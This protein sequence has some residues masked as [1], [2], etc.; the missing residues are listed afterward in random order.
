MHNSTIKSIGIL[1]GGGDCP[2]LNAVIRAVFLRATYHYGWRV[3]GIADGFEGLIN[4]G[5][6]FDRCR[7]LTVD[8]VREILPRGGTILGTTNRHN[9]FAYCTKVDGRE[10]VCDMSD[11]VL[12]NVRALE[13]DALIVVGG[14]GTQRIGLKLAEKGLRVVGVPKTIDNDLD[15]T[16]TTFGFDSA[17]HVATEALDRLHTTAEAHHRIMLLEVMG[18]DTGWIA[19]HAG[20]AGGAHAILIPEIPFSLDGLCAFLRQHENEGCKYS[21]IVVAEGIKLP[22]ELQAL[23]A[24]SPVKTPISNLIAS[25]I[26]SRTD[27]EV[28]VTVLGHIQRGGSPSPPDRILSSRFGVAAVELLAGD[29]FGRMVTLRGAGI[30][31]IPLAEAC[32]QIKMVDPGGQLVHT[33]RALGVSFGDVGGR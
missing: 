12:N 9:P 27:H 29:R 17:V 5:P 28:R 8:D 14:D 4:P 1:T 18:C 23:H 2:G 33:A 7:P 30:D 13:L 20:L 31:S 32:A 11:Q 22:D 19:L 6:S 15:A 10:L 24:K 21:I 25:A 3:C 26:A 16:D